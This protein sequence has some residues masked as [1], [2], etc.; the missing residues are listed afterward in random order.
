[1]AKLNSENQKNKEIKVFTMHASKLNTKIETL[2]SA[3]TKITELVLTAG[4]N[5]LPV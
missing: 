3:K 2:F 5:F 4:S 1:M